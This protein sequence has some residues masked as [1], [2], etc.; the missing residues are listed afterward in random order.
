MAPLIRRLPSSTLAR[1]AAWCLLLLI[2]L[3]FTAPFATCELQN[4]AVAVSLVEDGDPGAQDHKLAATALPCTGPLVPIVLAIAPMN[5][6]FGADAARPVADQP[7][8]P[9]PLRL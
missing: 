9:L 8:T 5:L 7:S 4:A 3:P 1:A 2:A 6:R